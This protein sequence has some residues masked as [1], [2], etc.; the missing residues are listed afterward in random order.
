MKIFILN[1]FL[2]TGKLNKLS[3]KRQPLGLA[4]I[5]SLL[6]QSHEIKLLDANALNIDSK[7]TI[8]EIK[9]FNPEILILTSTPIDRWEVP[10]HAHIQFLIENLV[11]IINNL[12]IPYIILI[13]S[14]GTVMPNWLLEKTK[15]NFIVRNEPELTVF[16]LVERI[17]LGND[18]TKI[19]GISFIRDNKIINNPDAE[20]NRNLD[21]LPFPAYDLLPMEKYSYTYA[22]IPKPFSII[23]S[24][25]GCPFNCIYCLKVMMKD[26]YI[27][28]S[29]ENVIAEIEYLTKEFGIK[30]IYFQD[31][32]FTINKDR[33]KKICDLILENKTEIKWGCNARA[34]DLSDKLVK[35]MKKAG[36]VRINI[37][38]ETGSQK[39][40]DISKKMIKIEDVQK[41]INVCK[42]QDINIGI[43]SILNLP[44]E[45]RETI[46]ETEKFL[47]DNNLKTMS[48][49][50]LPLPYFETELYQMLKNQKG[51]DFT[52][53]NLEKYAGRVGV[54]QPPW[55]ARIYRWHYKYKFNSGNL[56][57]LKPKFYLKFM[58]LIKSKL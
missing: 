41:A 34:N 38:F 42:K 50:N 39:L 55:L 26:F 44:G 2:F 30:G 58:K 40:L 45:T 25:R 56:Y 19:K 17:S 12:N 47:A 15:V 13:G 1:P 24:S 23:M 49:P 20:R 27:V 53:E 46:K 11:S 35:K 43:Y 6:R 16:N 51:K 37:G 7:N 14:H 32:E 21:N 36:C 54:S 29:P 28:R 33:V 48:A 52:W 31:W 8:N 9:K 4:Y 10:S 57:F 22:D 18:I 5:A 3:R